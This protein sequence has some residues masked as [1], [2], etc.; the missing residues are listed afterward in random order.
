MNELLLVIINYCT[1]VYSGGY[2]GPRRS[3]TK[4]LIECTLQKKSKDTKKPSIIDM[5]LFQ[6]CLREDKDKDN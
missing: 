3:C 5:Q 2:Y 4:Q 6:E 1:Q